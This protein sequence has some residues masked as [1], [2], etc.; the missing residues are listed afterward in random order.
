MKLKIGTWNVN[1]IR[2]ILKKD[3]RKSVEEMDLDILCVQETKANRE[4]IDEGLDDLGFEY[5]YFNSAQRKGYSGTA[6]FSK[7]KPQNVFYGIGLDD[8]DDEGRV[9]TL[10]FEDF[11]LVN[12]YTP[13]SGRELLRLDY[14]NGWDEEFLKYLKNLEKEKP[15]V[16]CG[17]FN[18]AHNEIDL[19]NPQTNKTTKTKPGSAGFTDTEREN[20]T[21]IVESGFIDVFRYLYPDVVKY[22]WWSYMFSARAKNV[23][24]R[25][26]YFVISQNL[27][28]NVE[29]V[30]IL[31]EVFGSDHCPVVLFFDLKN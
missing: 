17:D 28:D 1:G 26:D 25:I 2:A 13:N 9:I 20:F 6:I 7:V 16:S 21:K 4:Q 12:V 27:K 19:K 11:F 22:T 8:Y 14:R 24:W 18:V 31:N 3:F 23:G 10:E 15:V 30:K 5:E 29:D